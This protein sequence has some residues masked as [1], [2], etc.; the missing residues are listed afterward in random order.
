MSFDPH[1]SP[2]LRATF[3]RNDPKAYAAANAN[4]WP[5]ISDQLH[6]IHQPTLLICGAKAGECT[7]IKKAAKLMKGAELKVLSGLDHCQAYWYSHV[8]VPLMLYFIKREVAYL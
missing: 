6:L 5:D 3:L 8:V 4:P 7:E 1:Y 2:E